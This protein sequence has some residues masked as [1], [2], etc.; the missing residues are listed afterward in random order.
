[1]F[2]YR[3]STLSVLFW[4]RETAVSP[5]C[6]SEPSVSPAQLVTVGRR[7]SPEGTDFRTPWTK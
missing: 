2:D 1:M 4:G 7:G 6:L 3:S 5:F